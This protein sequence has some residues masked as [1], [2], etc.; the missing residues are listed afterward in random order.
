MGVGYNNCPLKEARA[1]S[2]KTVNTQS[3]DR[4]TSAGSQLIDTLPKMLDP[5]FD[6][7][8]IEY[9]VLVSSVF[10]LQTLIG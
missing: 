7:N 10:T 2:L 9:F 3:D 8:S 1:F 5:F 6:R 4:C